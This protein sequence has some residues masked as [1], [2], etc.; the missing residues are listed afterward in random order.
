MSVDERLAIHEAAHAVVANC[1]GFGIDEIVMCQDP[2]YVSIGEVPDSMVWQYLIFLMAGNAAELKLDP[3]NGWTQTSDWDEFHVQDQ[4]KKGTEYWIPPGLKE[5]DP[6]SVEKTETYLYD[7]ILP[8]YDLVE[9]QA[10]RIIEIP[11]VWD[12]IVTLSG[13]LLEVDRLSGD[14]VSNFFHRTAFP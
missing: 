3:L 2:A 7:F 8:A 11:E 9:D 13:L 5:D 1:L 14:E 10:A 12:K 4:I 6:D